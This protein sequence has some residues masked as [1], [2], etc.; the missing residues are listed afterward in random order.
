MSKQCPPGKIL[1]PA[2]NRCVKIDGKIGKAILAA[3]APAVAK[4]APATAKAA[5]KKE[6]ILKFI[7]EKCN[8]DYDPISMD[9]FSDMT[10]E[11][12]E[13]L[14]YIGKGEK[15]NCYLLEN[16]YEIYKRAILS[17]KQARDPMDPSHE[18]SKDEIAKINQWM[19]KRDISC[20][21]CEL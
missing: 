6:T 4:A 18:I 10:E 3:A 14:I 1:N 2:T 12:L 15:K 13:S 17:K 8:N 21:R 11:Q 19:K 5:P 20:S 9:N 7:S 16:I